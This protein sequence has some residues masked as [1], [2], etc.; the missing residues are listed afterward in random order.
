MKTA[1]SSAA[2]WCIA[3]IK[4]QDFTSIGKIETNDFDYADGKVKGELTTH[5]A[6]RHVRGDVGGQ[7]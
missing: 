5:G 4:H 3:R 6:G 2:R 7:R 1:V